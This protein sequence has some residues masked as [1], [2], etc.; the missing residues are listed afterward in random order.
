[1][2]FNLNTDIFKQT[3]DIV[4]GGGILKNKLSEKDKQRIRDLM[5]RAKFAKSI[6]ELNE[7]EREMKK[8]DFNN[9]RKTISRIVVN[10][11]KR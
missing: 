8:I 3:S 1:M 11:Y 6:E 4:V 9:R 7:V 10:K 2:K 5:Q